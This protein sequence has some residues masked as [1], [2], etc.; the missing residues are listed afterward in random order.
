MAKTIEQLRADAEKAQLAA[1]QAE[2][3]L[4]A[5]ERETAKGEIKVA[6]DTIAIYHKYMTQGQVNRLMSF[7]ETSDEGQG[8]E[9][10]ATKRGAK[11][12]TKRP[13]KFTVAGNDWTNTGYVP[14]T[15]LPWMESEE[16]IKWRDDAKNTT[17]FPLHS[18]Y[19]PK[20]TENQWTPELRK[21]DWNDAIAKAKKNK[22]QKD[23][24]A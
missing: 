23:K 21:K 8:G 5:A 12:G 17:R 9:K 7:F 4:I 14:K 19:T 13:M 20:K 1:Q 2:E 18:S 11:A 24:S 10:P 3:A 16:G 22:K 15:Y 6:M